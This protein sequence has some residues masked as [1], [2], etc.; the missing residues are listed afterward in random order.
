ME[1]Y[2]D[3]LV[4]FKNFKLVSVKKHFEYQN[5]KGEDTNRMTYTFTFDNRKGFKSF[6]YYQDDPKLSALLE[7]ARNKLETQKELM[8]DNNEDLMD[9]I[10]FKVN[11]KRLIYRVLV[12]IVCSTF[13]LLFWCKM[14]SSPNNIP[15]DVIQLFT[16]LS[17]LIGGG[18]V[19]YATSIIKPKPSKLDQAQLRKLAESFDKNQELLDELDNILEKEY[20]RAKGTKKTSSLVSNQQFQYYNYEDE[21]THRR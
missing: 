14:F 10:N 21:I 20:G 9:D 3:D 8:E 5:A 16:T 6:T 19:Y 11:I 7:T 4:Y 12:T 17:T 18:A 2:I 15:L 1:N 13:H